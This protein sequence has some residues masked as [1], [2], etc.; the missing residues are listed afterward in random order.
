MQ[1][2]Q[3]QAGRTKVQIYLTDEQLE[4]LKQIA[5]SEYRSVTNMGLTFILEGIKQREA[6]A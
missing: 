5:E 4:K 1:E 3:Q 2:K 6:T